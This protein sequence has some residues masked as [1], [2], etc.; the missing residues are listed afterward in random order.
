MIERAKFTGP[1][2]KCF[3]DIYDVWKKKVFTQFLVS[4]T[5]KGPIVAENENGNLNKGVGHPKSL[6]AFGGSLFPILK[7]SNV[8]SI[9]YSK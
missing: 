3:E 1:I 9:K 4:L 8:R 6:K 7:S 5:L 2:Y